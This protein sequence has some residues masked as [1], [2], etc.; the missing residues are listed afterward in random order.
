VADALIDIPARLWVVK[1]GRITVVTQHCCE[2]RR[3]QCCA[4]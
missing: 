2:I 3:H 4:H 1:R